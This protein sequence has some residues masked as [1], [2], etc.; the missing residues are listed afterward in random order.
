MIRGVIFDCFGVLY[1]G[2]LTHLAELVPPE[3]R[4]DVHDL[5]HASDYGYIEHDEY[6]VRL[7]EL[8]GK[9]A[10]E[11]EAIIRARHIRNDLLIDLI[12]ELKPHYKIGLLSNVGRGVMDE[13]FPPEERAGLFDAVVLSSDI[14]MVKPHPEIYEYTLQRLGVMAEE[15]VMIDDLV[16]NIDGARQVGMQGIVYESPEQLRRQLAQLTVEVMA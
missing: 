13:L 11:V 8:V 1:R 10:K 5:S 12:R 3:R 15:S 9:P 6:F 2:S 4:Q 16:D 14:G 7:G